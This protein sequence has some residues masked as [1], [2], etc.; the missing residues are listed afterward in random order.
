MAGHGE[1][2]KLYDAL[3]ASMLL[4]NAGIEDAERVPILANLGHSTL[5]DRSPS[6]N[7]IMKDIMYEHVASVIHQCDKDGSSSNGS[8]DRLLSYNSSYVRNI[9]GNGRQNTL[10]DKNKMYSEHF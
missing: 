8:S 2:F 9:N 10:S 5:F 4:S 7:Q 6:N 3:L 1:T